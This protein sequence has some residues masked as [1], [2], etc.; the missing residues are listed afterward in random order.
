MYGFHIP[1][2]TF[3]I[4]GFH[5]PFAKQLS[6]FHIP[7]STFF[8]YLVISFENLSTFY[9]PKKNFSRLR[10]KEIC[11]VTND[12]IY[13]GTSLVFPHS[14][15]H[16][17]WF[18][19]DVVDGP[20]STFHIPIPHQLWVVDSTKLCP[21]YFHIPDSKS[22]KEQN[23]RKPFGWNGNHISPPCT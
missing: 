22:G 10:R 14:T 21:G 20:A 12:S 3:H 7:H 16:K 8:G 4:F 19:Q 23:L 5:R 13:V 2:S 17:K 18:P 9:I 6:T 1:H 11:I 15:F